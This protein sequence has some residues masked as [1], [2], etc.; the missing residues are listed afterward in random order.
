MTDEERNVPKNLLQKGW[1]WVNQ[2]MEEVTGRL[3][4]YR[5]AMTAGMLKNQRASPDYISSPME[6]RYRMNYR[7]P[8]GENARAHQGCREQIFLLISAI[9]DLVAVLAS[10]AGSPTTACA[11]NFQMLRV[12]EAAHLLGCPAKTV[13]K[14]VH[15]KKLACVQVTSKKRRFT[16]EQVQE[17]IHCQS[18]PS[19]VAGKPPHQY[20]HALLKSR[21]R[22]SIDWVVS[23]PSI[24][25][26]PASK[27][28]R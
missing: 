9:T 5:Q 2:Y 1:S 6:G 4:S 19:A 12:H 28:L 26:G 23:W 24:A 3:E 14:L 13:D 27:F 15:Q 20:H 17:F 10:N 18:V 7:E 25:F 11:D 22:P 8:L 21:S 16:Q